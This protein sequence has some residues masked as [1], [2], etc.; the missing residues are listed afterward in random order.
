MQPQFPGQPADK[1]SVQ[2]NL[3]DLKSITCPNCG[4]DLFEH[5]YRLKALPAL[6]SPT[7]KDEVIALQ[8]FVCKS[9]KTELVE[10]LIK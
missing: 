7:G 3:K 10:N 5:V 8:V 4:K 9:C 1:I 2:V 6:A